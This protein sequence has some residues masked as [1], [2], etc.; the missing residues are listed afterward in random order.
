MQESSMLDR[1]ALLL[2]SAAL[3]ASPAMAE[4]AGPPAP[5]R[6]K[7]VASFSILGDFVREVGG[8]RLEVATLV[9]PNGDAH[10]YS[11]SPADARTL[12]DARLVVVNGLNFEGWL[13]RLVKASGTKATLVTATSGIV[14]LKSEDHDHDHDHGHDHKGHDHGAFDPH[15]WQS[16]ANAKVYVANIRDALSAADPAG[17]E[18]FAANAGAY[19]AKLDQLESEAKAAIATIPAEK[20]RIITSHDAFQYFEKAYGIEFI[21]PNGVSTDAEASAKAVAK[22]IAQIRKQKIPAVFLENVTDPRLVKRIADETSAKIGGTLYS[23]A[24]TEP[25]GAAPTYIDMMRHNIKTLTG[26]LAAS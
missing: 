5:A 1:R 6:L 11:P 12:A 10:V 2:A 24:L 13:D 4:D 14:P 23:D 15:A 18:A 20:R 17:K 25:S 3:L 19:L 21:A 16:I 9:G 26:T 22:I 7:V 8:D